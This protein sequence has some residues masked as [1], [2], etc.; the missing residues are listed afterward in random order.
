MEH[1]CVKCGAPV[2]D[3]TAFCPNCGAPQIRVSG[4][5][6]RPATPPLTPGTPG[7]L[8]PPAEPVPLAA[9]AY[10]AEVSRRVDWAKLF[11]SAALAGC[12]LAACWLFPFLSVLLLMIAAG[13]FTVALYY[14]RTRVPLTR[15]MGAR[16]GA[17]GGLAAFVVVAII[18]GAE[19][20]AGGGR[21]VAMVQQTLQ[22]Q[23]AGNPDPR[24]Q[25]MLQR[26]LTPGGIAMLVTL[27]MILFLVMVLIFSALGGALSAALFRREDRH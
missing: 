20:A 8:Q 22:Q 6:N 5:A 27:G 7:E 1:A 24:A 2:E 23:I 16:I 9:P 10:Q 26:L 12:F 21:F 3:G 15:A 4:L 18:V 11:P 17:A 14:R 25:E 13:G 19:M